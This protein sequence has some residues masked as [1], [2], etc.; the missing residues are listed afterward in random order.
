MRT[1]RPLTDDEEDVFREYT[2]YAFNPSSALDDDELPEGPR[3]LGDRRGI[4]LDDGPERPVS[5][6]AHHWFEADVR[7][8]RLS[9][10]GVSAVATPPEFRRRGHVRAMLKHALEEYREGGHHVSILWPFRHAFYRRLGWGEVQRVVEYELDPEAVQPLGEAD[11]GRFHAL[12]ADDASELDAVYRAATRQLDLAVDRSP[13]WWRHRIVESW[14]GERHVYGWSDDAGALRGYVVYTISRTGGDLEL[15]VADLGATDA[16]AYRQLWGFLGNHDSQMDTIRAYD[17]SDAPLLDV[18]DRREGVTTSVHAGL[19]ARVVDVAATVAALS[20][21]DDV[22][23]TVT[24][25]VEDPLVE[26]HDRPVRLDVA[27][28][29]ATVTRTA[30]P[31]DVTLDIATLSGLVCGARPVRA[32]VRAGRLDADTPVVETLAT[33]FPPRTVHCRDSF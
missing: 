9:T 12:E 26:W 10:P 1:Y 7:G 5:V 29:S 27:D 33:L 4:F 25:D 32:Y 18:V 14:D 2:Q 17:R 31:A 21:P 13:D 8:C 3:R 16:T 28:G 22:D 11:R 23:T 30:G 20:Y 15:R 6:C 19:M 24:V